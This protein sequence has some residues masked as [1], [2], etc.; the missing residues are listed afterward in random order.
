VPWRFAG[1]PPS[2]SIQKNNNGRC[3]IPIT[4]SCSQTNPGPSAWPGSNNTS[5]TERKI[6]RQ[7]I[8]HYIRAGYPGLYLVSP[9]EQ[10]VEAEFK[11]IAKEIGFRLHV[12]SATAGLLDVT[13]KS[14]RDC[15][16]PLAVLLAVT[17]LPKE[18]I[19]LLRDIHAFMT[20]EPN[21]V[22]VRQFR[23]VLQH[24]KA[25]SKV[26]VVLGCRLCLPPELE[27]EITIIEFK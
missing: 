25:R 18:S 8:I 12:W 23:E 20:G 10:R 3:V 27:R 2:N 5:A 13:S 22:L 15:N 21:P 7:R 6:M 1:H 24:S 4:P 16:D 14:G 9:E 19:I 17:E 26:L 11:A